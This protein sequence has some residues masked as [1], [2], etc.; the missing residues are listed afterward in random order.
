MSISPRNGKDSITSKGPATSL[1]NS[2]N[3][4][5]HLENLTEGHLGLLTLSGCF[6]PKEGDEKVEGKA[7]LPF[8]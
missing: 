4:I 1:Y 7:E 8:S 6:V 3:E 5:L 2:I